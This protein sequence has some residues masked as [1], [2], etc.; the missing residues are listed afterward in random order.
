MLASQIPSKFPIPFGNAADVGTIR[1][2]P[3]ADQSSVTPGAASLTKGFPAITG[4]PLASGGIPPS[5]QDFNGVLFQDTAW[6]RW[7]AAGGT[8]PFDQNFCTAIGGYPLGAV[9][10]AATAGNL[11]LS[12]VDNNTTNP[13]SGL[14]AGW[15]P[16]ITAATSA[17]K[18][19]FSKSVAGTYTWTVP[20][21]INWVYVTCVGGGGGGSGGPVSSSGANNGAGGGAG[22]ASQ[23][24]LPVTPGQTISYVVGAGG[25]GGGFQVS[26]GNGGSSSVGSVFTATGG[27]G[28]QG[29]PPA[30]GVGGVGSGGQTNVYGGNGGDGSVVNALSPGGGGGTSVLGG[31]GRTASF[32][33]AG[34]SNGQAPGSGG[35]GTYTNSLNT[36]GSSGGQGG[37]GAAGYVSFQY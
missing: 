25:A 22:G 28:G 16:L 34:V 24:W 31:G 9:L 14:S 6:A 18:G 17:G 11:W 26:G 36:P 5:L 21:G 12:V 37:N 8:V 7:Q 32:Y 10:Q 1:Q 23:G 27:G 2:V 20:T 3:T 19:L 15:I 33:N 30:G 35:G 13:D 4:Q 29:T